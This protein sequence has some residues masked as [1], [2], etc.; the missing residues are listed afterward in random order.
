MENWEV[1]A[2]FLSNVIRLEFLKVFAFG[3]RGKTSQSKGANQH[4]TQTTYGVEAGI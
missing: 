3:K 2:N 4:Q 1:K